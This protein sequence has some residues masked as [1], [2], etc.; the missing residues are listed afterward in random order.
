MMSED[1][2]RSPMDPLSLFQQWWGEP[3]SEELY[4]RAISAP[5]EQQVDFV[6]FA[7]NAGSSDIPDLDHGDLRPLLINDGRNFRGF[8]DYYSAA[9]T[10]ALYVDEV[11]VEYMFAGPPEFEALLE[12]LLLLKPLAET[13]VIRFFRPKIENHRGAG[14]ELTLDLFQDAWQLVSPEEASIIWPL[15]TSHGHVVHDNTFEFLAASQLMTKA[16]MPSKVS[17][18]GRNQAEMLLFDAFARWSRIRPIDKRGYDM[19]KLVGLRVPLYSLNIHDLANLRKSESAFAEWRSAISKALRDIDGLP[20]GTQQWQEQARDIVTGELRPLQR[21]IE[22]ATQTSPV[23][24][25]AKAGLNVIAFSA[26]GAA[27]GVLAG[28]DFNSGFVG[29]A[30]TGAAQVASEYWRAVKERKQFAAVKDM[31]TAFTRADL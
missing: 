7:N 12:Y 28:G 18:L 25:K 10:L 5:I 16:A 2:M 1:L 30:T 29:A 14:S 11:A 19:A 17:L 24:T 13:G 22:R 3:L 4:E 27:A 20:D 23:L 15:T 6:E 21:K 9:S 31:I 8:D 26:I